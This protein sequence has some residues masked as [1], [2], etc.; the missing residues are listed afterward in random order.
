M[1]SGDL[2]AELERYLTKH[3]ETRFMEPLIAD[4]NGILRGKRV[5]VDELGKAFKNG[6]NMC[7]ATT[8][9]DTLGNTFEN[10]PY[11]LNDGDPD[12][13]AFAVPGSL[14][15][16]PWAALPTAQV[17]LELVNLDGSPNENDPRN[18]LRRAMQ[19][20]YDMGLRP[21]LATELEF[22]LVEY[23]G[24]HFQPQVPRVPGSDIRQPGMQYE[25]MEDLYEVDDFLM[26]LNAI[27]EEQN[28]PVGAALSEFSPGQYEVNLH[29]VDDPVLACDHAVLLKRA[30]KAAARKNGKAAT[31]MAKPFADTAGSGMHVHVSLLNE[32]GENVFAGK[33]ADGDFSDTLRHAIGGLGEAMAECVAL[34]APNANSYRRHAP[35]NFVAAAPEWGPNHRGVALRIP[36]SGPKNRR[37]EHRVAGADANPYFVVA[38][39]LAGIHHGISN[40][41]EPRPMTPEGSRLDYKIE[42]PIRWPHA[43]DAFDAG[44]ILPRYLGK[45]YHKL[46]SDCRREEET[47]YN[48]EIPTKDFEW[49]MRAV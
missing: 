24:Q 5:G 23:D 22:Y 30:V 20:L 11:G 3:P 16:V 9:L 40:Q 42:I 27:C 6:V 13:K 21:V 26:D 38:A 35:G 1:T 32:N 47:N 41:C 33:S 4:M 37:L 7:A 49:F 14:V 19:P 43:L 15:P 2:K 46:Y 48:A 17:L 39:I 12:A 29:H 28:I 34:F 45:D 8:L 36:L 25:V 10:I 44:E 31:F 18:V